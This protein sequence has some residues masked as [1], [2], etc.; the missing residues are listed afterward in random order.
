MDPVP[1]SEYVGAR[2]GK[3]GLLTVEESF[4]QPNL[5]EKKAI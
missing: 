4:L 3:H 5:Y 1:P 2:Q